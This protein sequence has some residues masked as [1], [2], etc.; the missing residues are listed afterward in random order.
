MIRR[1]SKQGRILIPL[2]LRKKYKL[3]PGSKVVFVDRDGVMAIMPAVRDSENQSEK[4]LKSNVD[5]DELLEKVTP[6]N[7]HFEF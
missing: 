6:E 2:G 4:V 5:L 1:I 3:E 7:L